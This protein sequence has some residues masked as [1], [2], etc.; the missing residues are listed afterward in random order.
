MSCDGAIVF[1]MTLRGAFAYFAE[2]LHHP[3]SGKG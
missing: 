3:V 1:V 2:L